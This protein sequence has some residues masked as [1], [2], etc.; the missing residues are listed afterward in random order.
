MHLAMPHPFCICLPKTPDQQLLLL[1]SLDSVP[2][3]LYDRVC[4]PGLFFELRLYSSQA[5]NS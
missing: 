3:L 1:F 4:V 2:V 5:Q